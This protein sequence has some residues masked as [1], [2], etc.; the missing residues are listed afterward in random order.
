MAGRL[1]GAA[2]ATAVF[3]AA[4]AA[5]SA[6]ATDGEQAFAVRED[7]MKRMGRALYADIGKVSRGK[8]EP[9]PATVTAAE[10]VVTLSATITNLFPAGSDVPHSRMKPEIFAARPEVEKLVGD[11]QAA[12]GQLL[13]A[14]KGGDKEAITSAYKAAE[15]ACDA[16]HQRFRRTPE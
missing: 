14:V 7:T 15:G 16:C 12:A 11:V 8:S 10:T 3:C 9:G 1:F 5:Y 13:A 4:F 2:A 6:A